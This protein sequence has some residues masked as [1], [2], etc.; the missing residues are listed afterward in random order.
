MTDVRNGHEAGHEGERRGAYPTNHVI[1][2]IDE[3]EQVE[4]AVETLRNS[5]FLDSEIHVLAGEAA[6]AALEAWSG[7]KGW[8]INLLIRVKDLLGL[9]D[10]EMYLRDRYEQ[11]LRAGRFV[12]LID[13]PSEDRKDLAARIL[14]EHDGHAIT[15]MGR[16]A[17]EKLVPPKRG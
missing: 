2:E 9:P 5:G 8:Y 4:R 10:D 1:G 14:R 12:L 16:F 17:I 13:T 15:F 6:A 11:S 7:R 3:R